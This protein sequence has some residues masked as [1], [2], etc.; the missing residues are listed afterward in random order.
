MSGCPEA[1]GLSCSQQFGGNRR[2]VE[3]QHCWHGHHRLAIDSVL[4]LPSP[5][6]LVWDSIGRSFGLSRE[7]WIKPYIKPSFPHVYSTYN[8][9]GDNLKTTRINSGSSV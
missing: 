4:I 7:G 1:L 5:Q 6:N 8:I 9:I 3:Q 2:S